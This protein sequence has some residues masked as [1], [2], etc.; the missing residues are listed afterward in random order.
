MTERYPQFYTHISESYL[1]R[2]H[3]WALYSRLELQLP[4]GGANTSNLVEASFRVLKDF[5]FKRQ[6]AYNLTE[7]LDVL[8]EPVTTR[9]SSGVSEVVREQCGCTYDIFS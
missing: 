6:K 3:K 1:H 5:I 4:T 7:L 2:V 9:S 8:V